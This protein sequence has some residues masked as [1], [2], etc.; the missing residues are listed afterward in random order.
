MSNIRLLKLN[1]MLEKQPDD[2]FLL[3]A[4]GMEYM[5]MSEAGKAEDMFR[6]VLT[7]EAHN[8]AAKYQLA[9]L[10]S[11]GNPKEAILL[12]EAGMRE[13]KLKSDQKTANEFRSLLDE[14][15]F[16]SDE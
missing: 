6:K 14:I 15:I 12:L 2:A 5:G 10:I 4:L 8:I 16:D 13:A 9:R 11:N 7:I 1:E 3:Y